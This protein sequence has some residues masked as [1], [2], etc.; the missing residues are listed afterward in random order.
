MRFPSAD[1]AKHH[2]LR[3]GVGHSPSKLGTMTSVQRKGLQ[4][5][6]VQRDE[7]HLTNDGLRSQTLGKVPTL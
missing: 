7:Q 4:K 3:N 1:E 6:K 5:D 2:H